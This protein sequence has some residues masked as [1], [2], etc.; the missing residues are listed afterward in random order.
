MGEFHHNDVNLTLC[1]ENPVAPY[2]DPNGRLRYMHAFQ[3]T[4][5]YIVLP[6]TSYMYDP[7][8]KG[9]LFYFKMAVSLRGVHMGKKWLWD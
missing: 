7:C 2:P 1:D 5:N 4:D 6:E 3:M 9:K 8:N